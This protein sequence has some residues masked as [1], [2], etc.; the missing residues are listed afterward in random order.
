M[1]NYIY[2][3]AVAFQNL[4]D[5]NYR[6]VLGKNGKTRTIILSFREDNFLH[7]T[8]FHKLKQYHFHK[9]TKDNFFYEVLDG[10]ITDDTVGNYVSD[11]GKKNKDNKITLEDI[12]ERVKALIQLEHL[13]DSNQASFFG[14]DSKNISFN[15][16]ITKAS[17]VVKSSVDDTKAAVVLSFLVADGVNK[18][19]NE[20]N[21]YVGS[22]FPLTGYDYTRRQTS[23]T[24]LLKEKISVNSVKILHKHPKYNI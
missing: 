20:T 11:T 16:G 10:K 13:I 5:V 8:G 23:Y 17:Y 15:T 19:F 9:M 24:L 12:L 4:L 3:A 22:M 7:L 1:S 14:Y 21:Y 18:N 2:D 6:I